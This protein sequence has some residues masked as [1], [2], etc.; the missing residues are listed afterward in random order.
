MQIFDSK[1]LVDCIQDVVREEIKAALK[2]LE[3]S[4]IKKEED[5]LLTKKEMAEE[6]DISLVT[7][8]DWMKKGLPHLRLNKRI[9]F[10]REEVLNAMSQSSRSK[11]KF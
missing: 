11:K 1:A 2:S 3:N 6:L 8:T 5:K 10:R 9:Y 4:T 7:L